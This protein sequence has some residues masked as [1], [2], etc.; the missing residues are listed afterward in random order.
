MPWY[1]NNMDEVMP[2][3]SPVLQLVSAAPSDPWLVAVCHTINISTQSVSP[4]FVWITS[5]RVLWAVSS[6]AS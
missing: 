6:L 3:V 5:V 1:R 2:G 4:Q